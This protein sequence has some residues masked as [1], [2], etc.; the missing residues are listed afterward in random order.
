MS[1]LFFV[2]PS[3]TQ[4]P[5]GRLGPCTV[6]VWKKKK[7]ARPKTPD[8]S[9]TEVQAEEQF[10]CADTQVLLPSHDNAV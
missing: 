2:L 6:G 8:R 5:R 1:F 3:L 7:T 9:M 4:P 10:C